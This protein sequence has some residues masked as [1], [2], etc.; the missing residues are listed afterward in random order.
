MPLCCFS[1]TLTRSRRLAHGCLHRLDHTGTD[2]AGQLAIGV[3]ELAELG[4]HD[5]EIRVGVAHAQVIVL[6]FG[7]SRGSRLLLG[8]EGRPDFHREPTTGSQHNHEE[9]LSTHGMHLET[10]WVVRI[11]G[12]QEGRLQPRLREI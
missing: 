9:Q 3:L 2:R 7:R 6:V 1:A 12:F 10:I 8:G 5:L 4:F 11:E